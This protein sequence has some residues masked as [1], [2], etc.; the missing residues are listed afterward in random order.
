MTK[1]TVQEYEAITC[2]DA[3]CRIAREML[4]YAQTHP[5]DHKAATKEAIDHGDMEVVGNM[6]RIRGAGRIES[7]K[8]YNRFLTIVPLNEEV[9]R[10]H[11]LQFTYTH[12]TVPEG[13]ENWG[14]RIGQLTVIDNQKHDLPESLIKYAAMFLQA[15]GVAATTDVWFPVKTPPHVKIAF[16]KLESQ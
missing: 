16:H 5:F 15:V 14:N 8:G 9:D 11:A 2:E 10:F 7:M 12:T 13:H 6:I 4:E 1:H 3:L